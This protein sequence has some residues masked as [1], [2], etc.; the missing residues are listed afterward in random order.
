MS[1]NR[2]NFEIGFGDCKLHE[3]VRIHEICDFDFD[4]SL[5]SRVDIKEYC[6]KL[7]DNANFVTGRLNNQ[8]VGLLAI[9]CNDLIKFTAYISSICVM[10]NVRGNK[11]GNDLLYESLNLAKRSGMDRIRLE[12]GQRNYSAISLYEK[13]D[14][15]KVEER[16]DLYLLE[17][18]LRH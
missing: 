16:N 4:P 18:K 10:P 15:K 6:Q 8:L 17:L 1:L 14:F 13:Y 11:L 2:L 9:Y 5:S 12:V 7:F 3:I